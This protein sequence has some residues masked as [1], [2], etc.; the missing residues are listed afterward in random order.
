MEKIRDFKIISLKDGHL[1]T[2]YEE[3]DQNQ[4]DNVEI[5]YRNE[6]GIHPD[7]SVA[8][9]GLAAHVRRLLGL[10]DG[11]GLY[12]IGFYKQNV[13]NSRL[14]TIYSRLGATDERDKGIAS[15]AARLYLGR[16][17]YEAVE[18]LLE[19]MG[20]C[21]REAILYMNDGKGFEA[22]EA[23]NIADEDLLELGKEVAH[24]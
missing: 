14:V 13:G 15:L 7:L 12:V 6:R 24:A 3:Y 23:I 19:A 10:P 8:M 16:D 1:K 9:Q 2:R 20:E 18:Q 5:T 22:D 11:L 21:E 4:D 17:D